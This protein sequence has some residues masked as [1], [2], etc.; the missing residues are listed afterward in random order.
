MGFGNDFAAMEMLFHHHRPKA[1][2]N[3]ERH[4]E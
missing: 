4:H 3:K 2:L 1:P